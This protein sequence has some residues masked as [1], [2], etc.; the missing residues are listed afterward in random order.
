MTDETIVAVFDTAAHADAAVRD[1]IAANVPSDA[2]SKHAGGATAGGAAATTAPGQKQ[3]FWSNM[4][5]GEPDHDTT[6]Y[7]RSVEAG[8]TVVTV[9]TPDEYVTAV[10]D[11]L[12]RHGPIDLDERAASY[13]LTQTTTT[14]TQQ[15]QPTRGATSNNDTM[16]LAEEQLVVGKRAVNRGNTRIRRFVVETPV[17]EQVTLRDETVQIQRR[18]VQGD[19][20]ASDAAFTDRTI[21]VTEMGEEAVVGKSAHVYEEVAVRKE[22]T[23]HTETV[24]D[25]VRREEVEVTKDSETRSTRI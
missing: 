7:D 12:E 16:Q 4:F 21:E 19:R 25:T 11:I 10:T 5:G 1:L 22:A 23:E 17:E 24:K 15:T 20:A 14:T 8:S 2:I 6:V 9:K 3:G 13:G 18:A